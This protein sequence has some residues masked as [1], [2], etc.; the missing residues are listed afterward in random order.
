MSDMNL[1][2]AQVARRQLGTALALFVDD[3]DPISVHTLACAGGEIAEHLTRSAGAQPF[4]AH[5]LASFPDLKM[6][7]LRRLQN[8][9]WNAFKHATTR[10]GDERNDHELLER[11]NDLQND[12]TLFV[13]WY[14]YMLA[15]GSMPVEAQAFQTWYFALYPEKLHPELDKSKY[16]ALFPG[17]KQQSRIEQ[18]NS[19]RGAIAWAR[20]DNTIMADM[21]TDTSPLIFD[22]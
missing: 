9:F 14:D 17:L 11:F 12:H 7:D 15:V 20:S 18:K 16:E 10:N 21:R 8:Q 19:L 3:L 1:D 5:A 4:V 2:K 6:A 22:N 13:A